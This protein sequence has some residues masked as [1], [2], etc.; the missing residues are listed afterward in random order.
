MCV[1]FAQCIPISYHTEGHVKTE[2]TS[3]VPLRSVLAILGFFMKWDDSNMATFKNMCFLM[4][5]NPLGSVLL[6][7]PV[8]NE[9]M[10]LQQRK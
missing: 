10:K 1:M 2:V 3:T 7:H 8:L 6:H 4:F 9:I 5:L